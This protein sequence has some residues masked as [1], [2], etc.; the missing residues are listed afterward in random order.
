ML[1]YRKLSL[2]LTAAVDNGWATAPSTVKYCALLCLLLLD[3]AIN[4]M[5]AD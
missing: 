5:V 3:V 2:A 4:N 1:L